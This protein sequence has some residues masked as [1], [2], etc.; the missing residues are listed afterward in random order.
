MRNKRK[1][2]NYF[3][4]FV[5]A[6]LLGLPIL[7]L[8]NLMFV[9][10]K[11]GFTA[12]VGSD[13]TN[14]VADMDFVNTA[15]ST[16]MS[17]YEFGFTLVSF[18]LLTLFNIESTSMSQFINYYCNYLL[19]VEIVLFI[20]EVLLVVFTMFKNLIYKLCDRLGNEDSF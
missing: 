14:Y 11:D 1:V 18:D 15:L 13:S 17:D 20:P 3:I 8:L 4:G 5:H 6:F 10:Y 16:Y 7:V 12:V 2:H 19:N 9:G